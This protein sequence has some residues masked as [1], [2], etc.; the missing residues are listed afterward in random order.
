M[1]APKASD[2]TES[3]VNKFKKY[4][5]SKLCIKDYYKL[6]EYLDDKKTLDELVGLR[7]KPSFL[8]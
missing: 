2:E 4:I 8:L 6:S 3:S 1:S 5:I 7:S